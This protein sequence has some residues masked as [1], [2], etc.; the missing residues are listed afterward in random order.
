MTPQAQSTWRTFTPAP[1]HDIGDTT[2][3]TVEPN[4]SSPH[5]PPLDLK[6]WL[7][8]FRSNRQNRPEPAW[9]LPLDVP[10]HALAALRR[11]MIE[12]QLGD[13]GG[14]A[15]LIAHD[16]QAFTHSSDAMHRVVDAWFEE[17]KGHARILGQL[18]DRLGG[19]RITT[20]W[21]FR[22]FCFVRW[23]CGVRF[24]LQIL[25]VTELTSTAYYTLLLRH[26]ADPALQDALGLI[27]RDEAGHVAFHVDRLAASV[28]RRPWLYTLYRL[29]FRL[30]GVA[31]AGVL[32][33]SHHRCPRAVGATHRDFFAEAHRQVSRFLDRLER[34][35]VS[36]ATSIARADT[37]RKDRNTA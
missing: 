27:L 33:A 15:S 8:H 12:F 19:G 23:A 35:C 11:S 2:S 28:T 32:W 25:T 16:A 18:V 22:L 31:A 14:P 10:A 21:S 20:C 29:Q 26:F 6:R 9:H 37:R 24:E 34:A 1:S 4:M 3:S 36:R 17:E 5:P 7:D 13:G 30:A